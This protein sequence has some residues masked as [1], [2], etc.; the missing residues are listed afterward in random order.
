MFMCVDE[1]IINIF[2]LNA[3]NI[4]KGPKGVCDLVEMP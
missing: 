1:K 4:D 3:I 2:L